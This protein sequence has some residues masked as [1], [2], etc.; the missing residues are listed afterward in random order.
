MPENFAKRLFQ[1]SGL[2]FTSQ[3]V[4]KLC[5]VILREEPLLIEREVVKHLL[6][7]C[8]QLLDVLLSAVNLLWS[9]F[10]SRCTAG[11]A[12]E[13]NVR[14]GMMVHNRLQIRC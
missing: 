9:E 13:R 1:L 2:G 3:A 4:T 12:F 8:T 7:Q 14:H 6:P 11:V 5:L 10:N